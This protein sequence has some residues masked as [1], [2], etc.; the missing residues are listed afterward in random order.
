[1]TDNGSRYTA[2]SRGN[3]VRFNGEQI[4]KQV[5]DEWNVDAE[6]IL[7]MEGK[8]IRL[9]IEGDGSR[10][11]EEIAERLKRISD[12]DP[13]LTRNGEIIYFAAPDGQRYSLVVNLKR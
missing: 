6:Y 2:F 8:A 13:N 5:L 4:V 9:S 3:K 11:A 12:Y 10:R 7:R 1:M